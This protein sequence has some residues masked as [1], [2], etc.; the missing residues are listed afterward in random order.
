MNRIGT[1]VVAL[2]A[3]LGSG[4]VAGVVTLAALDR[5]HEPAPAECQAVSVVA[6]PRVVVSSSHN[7]HSIVIAPSA[8]VRAAGRCPDGVDAVVVDEVVRADLDRA[9]AGLEQKRAKLEKSRAKLEQFYGQDLE[10]R[11]SEE[12]ARLEKELARMGDEVGR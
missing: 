7:G 10:R 1:D 3:I 12:M 2:A 8:R 6:A 5:G 9:L 4:A 11:L